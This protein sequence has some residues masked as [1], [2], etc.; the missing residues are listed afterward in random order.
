MLSRV[1]YQTEYLKS[2]GITRNVPSETHNARSEKPFGQPIY[3]E[4]KPYPIYGNVV[5]LSQDEKNALIRESNYLSSQYTHSNK[6][7][8]AYLKMDKNGF[9][10]LNNGQPAKDANGNIR[11]LFKHE[12]STSMYFG[13]DKY[14]GQLKDEEP[15]VVKKITF[16]PRNGG[17]YGV[18]GLY[19]PPGEV[20]KIEIS[21]SDLKNIKGRVKFHIGQALYNGQPN[22]IWDKR[23]INRM[24]VILNTMEINDQNAEFDKE[25]KIYTGYIGSFLGG[26]IYVCDACSTFTLIISGAVNYRHFILGHTSK[27]EFEMLSKSTAPYFDLE[28]WELG[29]L[30]SGPLFNVR[31]LSYEDLFKAA[32]LWEKISLVSVQVRRQGVVFLYDCFVAAGAAVA[33]PGR[34]SVNCPC[35]WMLNALN[36]EE[37][38]RNGAWG[39]IHEFNHNFQG[40]GF[41]GGGEVTN[42]ALNVVSYCSFTKISQQRNLTKEAGEGGLGGWNT[43]TSSSWCLRAA[44]DFL[45]GKINQLAL[46]ATLIHNIGQI[47]F[48]DAT[49]TRNPDGTITQHL[50][51]NTDQYYR[52]LCYSSGYDM[53]WYFDEIVGCAHSNNLGS[54]SAA[55]RE[56]IKKLNL[57]NFVP[58]GCIYQTGRSLNDKNFIST[59]KPFIIHYGEEYTVDLSPY[60]M[61]DKI[62]KGGS[63]VLPNGFSYTIKNVSNPEF[64]TFTKRENDV[65]VYKPDKDHLRSGK[66]IVSLE[67]KK[68]DD[69]AF[70]VDDVDLVIELEQSRDLNKG[71]L[72][73]TYYIFD[74]NK[75]KTAKEAYEKNYEGFKEKIEEDNKNPTQNS[76]TDMWVPSHP[77]KAV[78]EIRGKLLV[79]E[80]GN[81]RIAIRGR[82]STA[83]YLS[84]D[85]GKTY[86]FAAEWNQSGKDCNFQPNNKSTYHDIQNLKK[87]DWIF[88]KEVLIVNWNM[89]F[90]GLGCGRFE[91]N[92]VSIQYAN[93]YREDYDLAFSVPFHSDYLFRPHYTYNM[94]VSKNY[95]E[96]GKLIESSPFKGWDANQELSSLF[97]DDENNQ[98]HNNKKENGYVSEQKPFFITVDMEIEITA[99]QMVIYGSTREINQYQPRDFKLLVGNSVDDLQQIISIKDSK[100]VNKNVVVNF[101]KQYKFKFYKFICTKTYERISGYISFRCIKFNLISLNIPKGSQISPNSDKIILNGEWKNKQVP[102]RFG[103]VN[104]GQKDSMAKFTFNGTQFAICSIDPKNQCFEILVDGKKAEPMEVPDG[105]C[106]KLVLLSKPLQKGNH[107]VDI[108]C[109]NESN[110]ESIVEWE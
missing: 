48:I 102:S 27:E 41:P 18:T 38:T 50:A 23:E 72:R 6:T 94:N 97:D 95:N 25:R 12:A 11:K 35:G 22:N 54:P 7:P 55:S 59:E 14:S 101:D 99:N 92:N 19:A 70:K 73:R 68:D 57:P 104:V 20:I 69:E 67:I 4:D 76:N 21:E 84:T 74:G 108:K 9:L 36:Y 53:T 79:T 34:S 49:H 81:Y 105:G 60:K 71:L 85:N 52:S 78:L 61:D 89:A 96:K 75:F 88:F 32:V 2:D 93:A 10:F 62:Y 100:V 47:N 64:G 109:C 110:L 31:D 29:V 58:V 43:Y 98:I 3:P 28:V 65:Y 83:L 42:N 26:P 82:P 80:D 91:K 45:G 77:N 90:V 51:G 30:H 17:N 1:G 46:Y 16:M 106:D 103:R 13:T 24:P 87:G 37:F 86:E 15:A 33:F 5:K 63:I 56:E 39:V 40:Y 107:I 66:I 8:E 44:N